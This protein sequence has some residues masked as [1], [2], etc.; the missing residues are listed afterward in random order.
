MRPGSRRRSSCSPCSGHVR[1]ASSTKAGWTSSIGTP[2]SSNENELARTEERAGAEYHH[3][4]QP[5]EHRPP[6]AE[7]AGSTPVVGANL[8]GEPI[9]GSARSR[10]PM[11]PIRHWL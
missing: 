7:D 6:K 4:A 9:R 10:Q 11:A 2:S 1:R 3:V 8:E 5:D